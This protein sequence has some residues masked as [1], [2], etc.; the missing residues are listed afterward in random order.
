MAANTPETDA[1][2]KDVEQLRKDISALS[3][4]IKQRSNEQLHAGLDSARSQ[5]KDWTG[6]IESRPITSIVTAFGIGLLLG[7]IFS[8]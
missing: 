8:R 5:V 1:L 3:D 2:R 6:E 7:K 4:T